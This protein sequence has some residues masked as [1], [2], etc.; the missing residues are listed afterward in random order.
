MVEQQHAWHA[1]VRSL[2]FVSYKIAWQH[3]GFV[4]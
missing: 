2:L 3:L 1:F 4:H